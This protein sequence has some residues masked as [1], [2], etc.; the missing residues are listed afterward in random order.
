MS[1]GN[2]TNGNGQTYDTPA[3]FVNVKRVRK[4]TDTKGREQ[5]VFTFGLGKDR[6]GN[7]INGADQLIAALA[8]YAGKQIN[9]DFRV[10]EKT[11]KSGRTFPSAFCRI[12]EMIPKDQQVGKS[13]FVPKTTNKAQALQAKANKLA[14]Q[15]KG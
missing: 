14:D 12:V 5:Y 1:N 3:T 10:E 13:T 2:G 4:E 9:L 7:E 11:A 6:Q 15:F 8:P